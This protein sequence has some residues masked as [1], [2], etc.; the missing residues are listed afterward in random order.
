MTKFDNKDVKKITI[1]TLAKDIDHIWKD[2]KSALRLVVQKKKIFSPMMKLTY[3]WAM[4]GAFII[5]MPG[6]GESVL[7]IAPIYI[8]PAIIAPAGL[9]ML[10]GSFYLDRKKKFSISRAINKSFVM[11]SAGLML[12]TLYGFYENFFLSRL[13]SIALVVMLGA[14]VSI[15]YISAQTALHI[16]SDEKTRGRVFGI[17]AMLINLAMS[18][19]AIVVGGISDATSPF[20]A[21]LMLSVVTGLYALKLMIEKPMREQEA[22]IA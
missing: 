2:T 12:F 3:G 14:G 17:S 21:M 6:F 22:E 15:V 5:L 11:A 10:I 19:P 8:G 18:I 7:N 13:I 16:N 1:Y 20:Y 4:F 9:G